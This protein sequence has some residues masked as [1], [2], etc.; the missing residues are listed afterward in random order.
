M[1]RRTLASELMHRSRQLILLSRIDGDA[2]RAANISA[3]RLDSS[4]AG[5][6][7]TLKR[8]FRASEPGTSNRNRFAEANPIRRFF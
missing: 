5:F 8:S 3:G 4:R 7:Q 6:F 2:P 1:D